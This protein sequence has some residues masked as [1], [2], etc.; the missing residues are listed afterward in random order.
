MLNIFNII[1][2]DLILIGINGRYNIITPLNENIL[3]KYDNK[4]SIILPYKK[5][6]N[7]I[8]YF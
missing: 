5:L 2:K 4:I 6:P 8:N 1:F 3:S 7:L